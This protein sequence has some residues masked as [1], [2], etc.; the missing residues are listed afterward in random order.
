MAIEITDEMVCAAIRESDRRNPYIN[1]HFE[2]AYMTSE[3]RDQIGFLG[4]FACKEELGIDWRTG[5]RE[6]YIVPDSGDILDTNGVVDI[7]TETIPFDVLMNLVRHQIKDNQPYGRRLINQGQ[8][9]LLYHYDYVVWGA[10]PR[11]DGVHK[12]LRWYSL[13]YLESEY[14]LSNYQITQDTPF[15]SRYPEPCINVKHSELK[16]IW[17]L[18]RILGRYLPKSCL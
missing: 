14:I 13:G 17:E 15:G 9:E 6:D 10:F 12:T 11:P 2:L 5:I 7:K 18:K 3:M 8:V 16:P 4:E 1:H